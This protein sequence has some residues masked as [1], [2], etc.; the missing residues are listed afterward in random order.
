MRSRTRITAAFSA[1]LIL[2]LTGCILLLNPIDKARSGANVEEVLFLPSAGAVKRLSM[3]H[4]GLVADI[5][6]TRAVQYFG[7]HHHE[8]AMRYDLLYPY[9]DVTTTLDPQ[10]TVAYEFGS[11]FLSQPPPDGAG[12]PEKAI[13]LVERGIKAN[14]TEWKLYYNL[15]FIYFDRKDYEG[16]RTAFERGSRVPGAHP[17]LAVLAASMAQE[18]G[19]RE[20]AR[21]LW[22]K[23]YESSEDQNVRNN[24]MGRL[25]AIQVQEDMVRLEGI[26]DQFRQKTGRIPSNFEEMVA[27]GWLRGVPQDPTGTPYKLLPNGIIEAPKEF[28]LYLK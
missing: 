22:S 6:W 27:A 8:G 21:L 1:A 9:L 16:A 23:I 3:G 13:E 4:T 15:G 11:M 25:A 12:Q 26:V 24:A 17:A 20:T 2:A 14:P 18:S 7:S 28:L 5:Y 10:L 19:D